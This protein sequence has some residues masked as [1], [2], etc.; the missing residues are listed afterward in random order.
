MSDN[1]IKFYPANA[2]DDPDNV[3]EQSLGRFEDV[4]IIGWLKDD[5][6]MDARA[7]TGLVEASDLLWLIELF[8]HNLISG[9]YN[10]LDDE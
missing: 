3:L 6:G 8:K 2:A 9:A 7:S 10:A 5:G 1:V 4:L